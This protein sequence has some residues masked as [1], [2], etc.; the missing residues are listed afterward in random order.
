MFADP[1]VQT[2]ILREAAWRPWLAFVSGVD[3]PIGKPTRQESISFTPYRWLGPRGRIVRHEDEA[4]CRVEVRYIGLVAS[5]GPDLVPAVLRL[6]GGVV[7]R[8]PY[9]VDLVCLTKS[10]R[11]HLAI[12]I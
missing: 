4:V 5:L 12:P 10:L 3:K 7:P 1:V 2:F 9:L 6:E 11:T 8:P